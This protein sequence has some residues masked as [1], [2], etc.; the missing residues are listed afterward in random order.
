MHAVRHRKKSA[1]LVSPA[2]IAELREVTNRPKVIAK[3]RLIPGRVEEFFDT[4]EIA[5]T[6]L[7]G[8]PEHFIYQPNPDD[9][10]YVN[11]AL[12]ADAQLV[13]SRDKDLL[14]LM[15]STQA[16]SGGVPKTLSVSPNS[17]PGE[18]SSRNWGIESYC[19][20]LKLNCGASDLTV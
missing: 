12:A 14:D 13:V 1:A 19:R 17:R 7:D 15:D 5:A 20:P 11:L 6:I 18:V 9:A 4:V 8:F 3:L 16:R 2:V 10:H